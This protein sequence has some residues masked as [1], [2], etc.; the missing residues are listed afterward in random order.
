MF[1]AACYPKAQGRSVFDADAARFFAAAAITDPTQQN[2][3]NNMVLS[4]KAQNLWTTF[5]ALYPFVGGNAS[6]HAQNLVSA[7]YPITWTNAPTQ[8]ANGVT[9]NGTTQ[10]GTCVG[11]T[12]NTV[13]PHL[14]GQTVYARTTDNGA[15]S[16][17][18][19][20][21][22]NDA[23]TLYYTT[24]RNNNQYNS[25]IMGAVASLT[26]ETA[27]ARTG[28]LSTNRTSTTLVTEY[29]N[30]ISFQTNVVLDTTTPPSVDFGVLCTNDEAGTRQFFSA[31]N[32]ALLA[33][34]TPHNATQALNFH[35]IIEAYQ[36]ALGRGVV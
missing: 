5:F 18:F 33:F 36:D 7:L 15:L 9:G 30:G 25:F 4:L 24:Y 35:A 34:H 22:Q 14:H 17:C 8:D 12:G 1:P 23:G 13:V 32:I 20:G 11:L 26:Q 31:A 27:A 2:A 10:Y 3:V 28:T 6:A 29:N 16:R 21:I 19:M